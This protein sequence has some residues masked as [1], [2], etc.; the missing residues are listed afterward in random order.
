[1][2]RL[3]TLSVAR[4][5]PTSTSGSEVAFDFGLAER[6]K[7]HD[8]GRT[9]ARRPENEL[10]YLGDEPV[11]GGQLLLDTCVY[12]DQMKGSTPDAVDRLMDIRI[13][14]HSMVAV[15]ELMF[16]IGLLREDDPRTA[17]VKASVERIVRGMPDHRQLVPDADVMGRAAVLAGVLS[18]M[19]G[20]ANDNRFKAMNDCVLFVQAEKLG[21]TLLTANAAEYD[22]LL[23]V[24]PQVRVLLYRP[25]PARRAG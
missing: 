24:R 25:I 21:L 11:A 19:Q 20:Y 16:G 22:I 7:R 3:S 17:G 6:V 15:G 1:M 23:Q 18:R 5:T 10:P 12:V 9:L 13:V 8:P 2:P 4:S 14:N